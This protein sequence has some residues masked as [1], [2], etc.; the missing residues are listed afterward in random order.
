M[1]AGQVR[2]YVSNDGEEPVLLLSTSGTTG[3]PKGALLSHRLITWNAIN[4]QVSW[5]LRE[6]DITPT[7]APF[8]RAGGLNVLT[9][10]LYCNLR[11]Y[12]PALLRDR[13]L[14]LSSLA[15]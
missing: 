7:F 10:P 3:A 6:T 13:R 1:L 2:A 5:S 11:P 14:P 8:F 4:T 15:H 9:T 12:L